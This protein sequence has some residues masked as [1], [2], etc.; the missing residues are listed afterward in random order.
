MNRKDKILNI[1]CGISLIAVVVVCVLFSTKVCDGDIT[2]VFVLAPIGV[3]GI[4]KKTYRTN[5]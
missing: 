3:C 2:P 5:G 4:M 1:L